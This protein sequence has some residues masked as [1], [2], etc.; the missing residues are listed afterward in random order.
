MDYKGLYVSSDT[1]VILE[2]FLHA[3]DFRICR[4]TYNGYSYME[5]IVYGNTKQSVYYLRKGFHL[6]GISI[7]ISML[8]EIRTI[9]VD[10]II[11]FYP[12]PPHSNKIY[13]YLK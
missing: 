10:V 5:I 12:T 7:V 4:V 8:T 3:Y 1:F 9:L 13:F 6:F 2:I 11:I